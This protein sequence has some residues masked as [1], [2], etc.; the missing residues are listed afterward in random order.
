MA[1]PEVL[2]AIKAVS[3]VGNRQVLGFEPDNSGLTK[4]IFNEEPEIH[5]KCT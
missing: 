1:G 5:R 4:M 2:E 3:V